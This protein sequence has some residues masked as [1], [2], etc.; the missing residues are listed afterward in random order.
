MLESLIKCGAF[1]ALGERPA[2][3][4]QL[5]RAMAS[6]AALQK[7]AQRGQ[8]DLFGGAQVAPPAQAPVNTQAVAIPRKTILAWEKEHLGAYLSEHPLTDVYAEAMR[9]GETYHAISELDVEQS[10]QVVRL[11]GCVASV[12]KMTTRANR[13]MAVVTLEDLAGAVEL[14][15]FP[16]KFD[17]FGALAV[18]DEILYVRGKVDIRN[19]A[20]QLLVED[21]LVYES[22]VTV[23]APSAA[24][25]E[26]SI[27]SSS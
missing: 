24:I 12:R 9:S 15:L 27:F 1:D 16:E 25:G 19:D 4:A 22:K 10:G 23:A 11:L 7:A 2:L 21:M 8:M 5:D 13:T 14:V 18:E 6:G 20:V 26:A 3:L 17:R